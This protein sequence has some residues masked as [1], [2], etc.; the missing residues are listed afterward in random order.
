MKDAS[1]SEFAFPAAA[2]ARR[3]RQRK[4]PVQERA[5]ATVDAVLEA[6]LQVLKKDGYLAL[7][8]TQVAKRAGVSVGTLYQYFPDKASLVVA[9]KLRY[10]ERMVA[11]IQTAAREVEGQPLPTAIPALIEGLL[12]FKRTN[13]DLS[14]ALREPMLALG[15]EAIARDATRRLVDATAEIFR[16]A[17]PEL[18]DAIER[19]RILNA[20]IEGVLTSVIF[21]SPRQVSS[22]ELQREL[23]RLAL[24]YATA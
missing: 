4:R 6:T 1:V 19:A 24:A 22:P 16:R 15:G 18:D 21:Q 17:R 13:L 11:A 5:Q 2:A 3:I 14:I 8:T 7:T 23:T 12:R 9:L 10:F 20:A